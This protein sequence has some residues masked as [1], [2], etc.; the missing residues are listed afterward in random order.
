MKKFNSR[1]KGATA[2][3]FTA[4]V[5]AGAGIAT[6]AQALEF[7]SGDLVLAMYGNNTQ[8]LQ[9]LGQASSLLAPPGGTTINIAPSTLTSVGGTN[10]VKWALVSFSYDVDGLPTVDAHSSTKS[11][12]AYTALELNSVAVPFAWNVTGSWSGQL[13][14]TPGSTQLIPTSDPNSFTSVFG[15]DGSLAGAYPVSAEG[16]FGSLLSVLEGNYN[17]NALAALGTAFLSA[18]GSTLTFAGV[19]GPAP[20]PVPAA[21]V[22]FGTGLVGL[23]GVARRRLIAA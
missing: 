11:L 4:V 1:L 8:F 23:V 20:V 22:L 17:T 19:T 21:V 16:V 15:T 12:S 3:L 5:L 7:G 9:N 14:V 6:E 18:D 10:P 13:A 2:A